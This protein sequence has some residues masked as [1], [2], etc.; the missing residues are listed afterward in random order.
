[1]P[2]SGPEAASALAATCV[3]DVRHQ[4][5]Q[6]QPEVLLRLTVDEALVVFKW[7]HRTND[8]PGYDGIADHAEKV[9]AMEPFGDT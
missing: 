5:R 9:R 2:G 7:Q 1:M 8:D 6:N 3:Q 4:Q